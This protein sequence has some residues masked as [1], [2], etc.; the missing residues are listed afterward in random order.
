MLI[1]IVGY[2]ARNERDKF[3]SANWYVPYWQERLE[4]YSF[5][6]KCLKIVNLVGILTAILGRFLTLLLL[7]TG[8]GLKI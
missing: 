5:G 1:V 4:T 6:K 3:A 7:M 8:C 2:S